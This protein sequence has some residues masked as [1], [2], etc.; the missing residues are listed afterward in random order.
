[1]MGE[2]TGPT[3][4]GID[5]GGTNTRLAIVDGVGR[6]IVDRQTDT[7]SGNQGDD[8]VDWL[9]RAYH[10][11]RDDLS[12]SPAPEAIG[13]GVPGILEPGRSA[14][15]NAV[16]LPY[17]EGLPIRDRLVERTGLVTYVDCDTVTACW[18]EYCVRQKQPSRF[19]YLTIGTGIGGAVII[20]GQVLRHTHH[21]AG[22]IGHLI[23][24]TSE[25]ARR[26]RCGAVGC[27]EAHVA[28]PAI[29]EAA[30][31]AGINEGIAGL[32]CA[33]QDGNDDA[34]KLV[35]RLAAVLATG[36]I[37]LAHVYPVDMQVVG[38]GVATGLPSLIRQAASTAGQS[39]STLVPQKMRVELTAL[40]EYAGVVGAALLAA[41]EF[42]K[43]DRPASG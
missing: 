9:D 5:I 8:L 12:M 36:F 21:S 43:R 7:P 31:E 14:V 18:G 3:F 39:E 16:N 33:V 30:I 32:E 15:L 27:L 4:V 42:A 29:D 35:E 17:I 2:P 1:M 24:N 28:G 34:T 40:R 19:A 38:G 20:D 13:V 25:D 26:C 23:C 22:H 6:V 11:C 37:N 41:D 10:A